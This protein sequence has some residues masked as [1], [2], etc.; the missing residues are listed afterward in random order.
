MSRS[1]EGACRAVELIAD[2]LIPRFGQENIHP[3]DAIFAMAR[4]LGCMLETYAT[5]GELERETDDAVKVIRQFAALDLDQ[6]ANSPA[7]RA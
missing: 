2:E 6:R 4:T 3:Q 1:F 5:A 7:G